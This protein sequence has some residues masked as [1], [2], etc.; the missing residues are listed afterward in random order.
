[1]VSAE[2]VALRG[3]ADRVASWSSIACNFIHGDI[4]G[5]TVS[6]YE[7]FDYVPWL[8]SSA[9]HW[10]PQGIREGLL[11]GIAEWSVWPWHT[12][13]MPRTT[14]EFD[15]S[16]KAFTGAFAKAL[17]S[18]DGFDTLR[19]TKAARDDLRDRIAISVGLLKLP[20]LADDLASS[21]LA[22]PFLRWYF[23]PESLRD[24]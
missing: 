8:V 22:S 21:L 23:G 24:R 12:L 1:V 10:M 16:D 20:E 5:P 4:N 17:R 6:T 11:R 3:P 9:S 14:T 7:I 15:D 13:R 18:A 2:D 19:L